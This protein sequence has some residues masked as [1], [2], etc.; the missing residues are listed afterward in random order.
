MEIKDKTPIIMSLGNL[1]I[2]EPLIEMLEGI[3]DLDKC[4]YWI[5]FLIDGLGKTKDKN[6][7]SVLEGALSK[8]N[9]KSLKGRIAEALWNITGD[10]TYMEK[11][12]KP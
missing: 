12:Y 4:D 6:A 8:T 10:H 9:D 3:E 11:Y 7:V 5:D 1:G 2:A